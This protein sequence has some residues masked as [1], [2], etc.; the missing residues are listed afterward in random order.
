MK[1]EL[2]NFGLIFD[3]LP[4]ELFDQLKKDIAETTHDE[5]ISGMSGPGV[6][7]H[8][9]L[10]DSAPLREYVINAS[11]EFVST[12]RDTLDYKVRSDG[13]DP[14]CTLTA[15]E[16][17]INIQ[18]KNQWIPAHDHSGII[19]YSIWINV[20]MDNVFEILYSTISGET[21]KKHIPI[22]RES[23]GTIIMFPSKLI[24][25]VHPFHDGDDNRISIS[26]NL[27]L[28]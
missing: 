17:W 23:E 25:C 15:L 7:K 26:G 12:Y 4:P 6:P 1:Y 3:K 28:K 20:P 11:K 27:I 10:N 19:A 22:T 5:M 9:Y 21:M 24:H 14:N 18:R 8:Y 16:P 2:N 13:I